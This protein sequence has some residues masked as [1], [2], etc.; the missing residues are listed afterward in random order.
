MTLLLTPFMAQFRRDGG[1]ATE[2]L[3]IGA[4]GCIISKN[5]FNKKIGQA[6]KVQQ[7]VLKN[8]EKVL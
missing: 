4:I 6:I 1:G 3:M 7:R 8:R 5:N 2:G